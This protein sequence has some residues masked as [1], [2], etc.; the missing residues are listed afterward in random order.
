VLLAP[1]A[2]PRPSPAAPG[3]GSER[4]PAPGLGLG[5]SPG[6]DW[7]AGLAEGGPVVD[8]DLALVHLHLVQR[9]KLL[10]L[11][12]AHGPDPDGDRDGLI[13]ARHACMVCF[14]LAVVPPK[15]LRLLRFNRPPG[16][17]CA[18]A[19]DRGAGAS[20]DNY[21]LC[22]FHAL[23][24]ERGSGVGSRAQHS[25]PEI[26][27]W[28]INRAAAPTSV[29]RECVDPGY[30]K[31][32]SARMPEEQGA[33]CMQCPARAAIGPSPRTPQRVLAT[34]IAI[35]IGIARASARASQAV[36]ALVAMNARAGGHCQSIVADCKRQASSATRRVTSD[37]RD[38]SPEH[39]P[40]RDRYKMRIASH[41]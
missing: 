30:Q 24:F 32:P 18:L 16:R 9:A 40:A 8:E 4:P 1:C 2:A 3:G 5:D 31:G 17:G 7:R 26:F 38:R 33:A 12:C 25:R 19:R 27:A 39:G 35:G 21:R 13:L 23:A 22:C 41:T 6:G 29:G 37:E 15:V 10:A 28:V 20:D 36:L 14:V 11:G 34:R